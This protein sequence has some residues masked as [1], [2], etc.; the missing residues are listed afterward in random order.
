MMTSE[1]EATMNNTA[2][3]EMNYNTI[4]SHDDDD[5]ENA[6]AAETETGIETVLISKT[7]IINSSVKKLLMVTVGAAGL[8][9]SG[10]YL[11]M[12]TSSSSSSEVVLQEAGVTVNEQ[13]QQQQQLIGVDCCHG[14]GD[15]N[16]PGDDN[17]NC[18][19]QK[20]T[21]YGGFPN[22]TES[23]CRASEG[24]AASHPDDPCGWAGINEAFLKAKF[25]LPGERYCCPKSNSEHHVAHVLGGCAKKVDSIDDTTTDA[26]QHNKEPFVIE[27]C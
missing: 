27:A 20:V 24:Y 9:S 26:N 25:T 6:A 21:T 15:A 1:V 11:N 19:F 2:I 13:Q 23:H 14:G 17:V 16:V 3:S 22:P 10:G 4:S 12:L 18:V 5:E 8:Y 7:T